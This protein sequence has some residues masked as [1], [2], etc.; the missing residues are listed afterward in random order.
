MTVKYV[1]DL[2]KNPRRIILSPQRRAS[3]SLRDT[4][5]QSPVVDHKTK[6]TGLC[7]GMK[8]YGYTI[9]RKDT[10]PSPYSLFHEVQHLLYLQHLGTPYL[11]SC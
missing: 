7:D 6:H 4:G 1:A 5:W 9:Q 10:S 2:L 3:R 8:T 11:W